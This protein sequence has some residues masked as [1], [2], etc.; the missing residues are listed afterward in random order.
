MRFNFLKFCIDTVLEAAADWKQ[1]GMA[2][3]RCVKDSK[4]AKKGG[5]IR[6]DCVGEK[7]QLRLQETK[8]NVVMEQ[9]TQT[10]CVW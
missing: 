8:G 4:Y 1:Y 6:K 5:W 7:I 3:T 10:P 2:I 9:K